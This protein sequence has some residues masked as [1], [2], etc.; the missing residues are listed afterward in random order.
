METTQK[1]SIEEMSPDEIKA[2]LATKEKAQKAKAERER[3]KYEEERDNIA[4]E[5]IQEAITLQDQIRQFKAKVHASMDAQQEALR[6][7]GKIR[8]NSKGG[9]QIVDTAGLLMVKRRRETEP[10][11]DAR[12]DK[13]VSLLKQF[14]ATTIKKRDL[15]TYTL[16]MGFLE[17]NQKGDLEHARVM[18]LLKHEDLYSEEL[19]VEGCKLVREGYG[20][21]LKAFG[22]EFKTKV[23]SDENP[24][25]KWQN[26]ILNFAS[27]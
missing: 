19:W 8:S 18:E 1:K 26:I 9:F 13:G 2:Y 4:S 24:D 20:N 7:Y 16:L 15:K 14:L 27:L 22:Y 10:R 21:F 3:K 11:W 23:T 6:S 17:K 5:I 12:A 25:G